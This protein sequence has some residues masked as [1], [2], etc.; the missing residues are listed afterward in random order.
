VKILE[1]R[2]Y[3]GV[4]F[5]EELALDAMALLREGDYLC[6]STGHRFALL[7]VLMRLTLQSDMLRCALQ[8]W[9]LQEGHALPTVRAAHRTQS[10][11][12]VLGVC[13][14]PWSELFVW[15]ACAVCCAV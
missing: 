12:H 6:L 1:A 7:N 11:F 10:C 14:I 3:E 4:L 5:Q 15:A 9:R 8:W 2:V 13:S